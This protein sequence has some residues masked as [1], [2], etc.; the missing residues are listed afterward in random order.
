MACWDLGD[1]TGGHQAFVA[2]GVFTP[3]NPP[4]VP[5]EG[6]DGAEGLLVLQGLSYILGMCPAGAVGAGVDASSIAPVVEAATGM[7]LSPG[8]LED[9]AR[10]LV[11]ETLELGPATDATRDPVP[12]ELRR[13]F[14]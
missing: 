1:D 5:T 13:R 4:L 2:L 9:L 14:G 3:A 12:Q 11:S 7:G 8:D 10:R 6:A